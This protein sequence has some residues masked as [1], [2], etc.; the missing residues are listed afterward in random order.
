MSDKMEVVSFKNMLDLCLEDYKTKGKMVEIDKQYFYYPDNEEMGMKFADEYVRLPM[1]P[2]AGPQTQLSQNIIS[3]YLMGARFFELKTVQVI[4]G[5]DMR[6]LIKKP[7]IDAR[8]VGYNVE[9]STELSIEEATKE[10]INAH[11]LLQV[12]AIELGISDYKDFV[13]NISVGYSIEGI[14]SKEVSDFIDQMKD[15]KDT[16]IFIECIQLLKENIHQFNR[17]CLAD[18]EKISSKVISS[19]TTST[20]HGCKAEE[21]VNIGSYL[22][23]QKKLNTY[24]KCNPTLLGYDQVRMILNNLGYDDVV[25]RKEDFEGDLQYSHAVE[26]MTKLLELGKANGV[27]VGVKLTNTLPVYNHKN[28]LSGETMYLS[29]KPLYPIALSVAELFANSFKGDIPISFSGGIDKNNIVDVL[30]TGIAPVTFSTIL[31]KPRGY[32]NIKHMVA[33]LKGEEFSFNHLDVKALKELADSSKE[34]VNYKN[35]GDGRILE[36]TLPTYDCFK[37]NC[38][39][40]VDVCPNRANIKLYDKHFSAPYQIL[41]LEN[42]C[43]ECDNCHTFCPKGGFPYH[44]KVTLYTSIIEFNN[45]KNTGIL[46]IKDNLYLLRNELGLEYEYELNYSKAKEE[47]KELEVILETILKDDQYLLY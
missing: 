34:N 45:S 37:V 32:I 30:K 3:A 10:Y 1:G 24:I 5:K 9:W 21:I 22:I 26:I 35:K 7:C 42:K 11:T 47:K 13:F 17:F 16:P 36:D 29:G 14:Q 40:C 4:S 15:A 18:I 6:E 20:M 39:I 25:I 12:L 46:K 27:K 41:H 38:G 19:I 23:V 44:K 2:A 43:N 31:L 33:K 8:N 28:V